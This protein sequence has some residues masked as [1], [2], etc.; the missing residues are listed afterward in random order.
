MGQALPRDTLQ[1]FQGA[2]KVGFI[3]TYA[4]TFQDTCIQLPMAPTP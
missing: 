1:P 2:C 4:I 3:I